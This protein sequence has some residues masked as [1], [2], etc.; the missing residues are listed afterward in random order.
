MVPSVTNLPALKNTLSTHPEAEL[1]FLVDDSP[2]NKGYHITEIKHADIKSLDCGRGTDEWQEIII[3]ILDGS[4]PGANQNMSCEKFLGI[5]GASNTAL[6]VGAQADLFFEF[7]PGNGTIQRMQIQSI[8]TSPT[9]TVV[10]LDGVRA[11]CKPL[12]KLLDATKARVSEC[13]IGSQ[14]NNNSQQ[15]G[16]KSESRRCC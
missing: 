11:Q 7:S 4:L 14:S 9:S 2:I 10:S 1:V 6:D 15:H 12:A 8:E 5:V 13:C 3:Q 16:K